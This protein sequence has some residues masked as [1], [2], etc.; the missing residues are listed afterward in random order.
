M[1]GYIY[2][3]EVLIAISII[4]VSMVSLFKLAPAKPE[5]EISIIKQNGYDALF[6]LDQKGVLCD[7]VAKD[8]ETGIEDYLG[9]ILTANIEFEADICMSECLTDLPGTGAIIPV[10][11]YIS[12]CK[13]D[14]VGKKVR[15]F[16][17]KKA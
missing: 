10:D 7:L 9:A 14:Y 17:W 4:V 16:L 2:T 15:L 5:A 3:L 11:Y 12:S 13:G 1:K 8:N 6:Y